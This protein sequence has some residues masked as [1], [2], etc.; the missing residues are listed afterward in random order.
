MRAR[1]LTVD[2]DKDMRHLISTDLVNAGY[3]VHTAAN[4]KQAWERMQ[5]RKFDLLILDINMPEVNGIRLLDMV[6]DDDRYENLSVMMLT[7]S[8]DVADVISVRDR[9]CD[10]VL[11]PYSKIDLLYR[12]NRAVSRRR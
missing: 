2:D 9:A 6:R 4:A 7:S 5:T 3:I 12:V 10:Y 8:G 1:I 11:K